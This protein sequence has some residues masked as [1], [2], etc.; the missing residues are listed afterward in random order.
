MRILREHDDC[1]KLFI[2]CGIEVDGKPN[3]A[4]ASLYIAKEPDKLRQLLNNTFKEE[5]VIRR[6]PNQKHWA[7]WQ[8]QFC[9]EVNETS[10][11]SDIH[12][13]YDTYLDVL[14]KIK[15]SNDDI[16]YIIG[17]VID[18]GKDGIKILLD[19][20]NRENIYL[21]MGTMNIL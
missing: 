5:F 18:R 10:A 19:I 8:R 12:G 13:C 7:R 17:D 3:Y 1:V 11:I 20:L 6:D 4:A 16:Q 2:I 21:L 15:F 9:R 14:R